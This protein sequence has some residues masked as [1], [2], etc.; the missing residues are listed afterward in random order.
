MIICEVNNLIKEIENYV[1]PGFG[2]PPMIP[3]SFPMQRPPQSQSSG[4]LKKALVGTGAGLA[5]LGALGYAANTGMIN[6]PGI[7][8]LPAIVSKIPLLPTTSVSV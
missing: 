6:Y 8:K 2:P 5:G 1:N 3:P 4:L 7:S